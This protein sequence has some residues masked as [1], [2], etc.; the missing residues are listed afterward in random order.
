LLGQV[1]DWVVYPLSLLP[2]PIGDDPAPGLARTAYNAFTAAVTNFLKDVLPTPVTPIAFPS[3][4]T[5]DTATDARAAV[6]SAVPSRG[7]TAVSDVAVAP[8]RSVR[9][10]ARASSVAAH[11]PGAIAGKVR[12]ARPQN[13]A[14]AETKAVKR[15]SVAGAHSGARSKGHAA[16]S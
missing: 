2:G 13:A 16:T 14:A 6:V 11:E 15:V 5:P 7:Q 1:A 9:L 3:S 8:V 10:P 4:S 12:E